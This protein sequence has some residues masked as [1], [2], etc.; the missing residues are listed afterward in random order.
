MNP[1]RNSRLAGVSRTRH[2]KSAAA[3]LLAALA[4]LTPLAAQTSSS[5]SADDIAALRE[6]IRLLDQKI[7]ILERN[8]ELKD[9]AA[10]AAAAKPAAPSPKVSL[11]GKGFVVTSPDKD[12]SL[13]IGAL[14][15]ADARVFLDD[16]APNRDGFLLRRI[17]T[18]LSGTVGKIYNFNIT[19]EYA[20]GNSTTSSVTLVDAWLDARFSPLFGLKAGKYTLPVVLEPGSNRHFNESPFPNTLAPNRDLGIEAFGAFSEGLV[21]YRLGVFNG[22]PNNTQNFG[23]GTPWGE[24]GDFT[25][26]GRLT[27]VPFSKSEGAL[28]KLALSVGGSYGNE[29]A[30]TNGGGLTNIVSN[31]QQAVL[32][33]G[34]LRADGE[35]LRVSPGIE[36]YTGGPFSAAA[37]FIWERQDL[38]NGTTFNKSVTNT[39]WRVSAGYVL[40]GEE[41]TKNGVTPKTPFNWENGTWG[42]F[43][44]VGRLSGL[45]LDSKLFNGAG[46][47]SDTNNIT[48]AFSYGVGL[49]WYLTSNVRALFNV[50]QTEYDG[51]GASTAAVGARS[52]ELYF[53]TRFQLQF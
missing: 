31:G 48:G 10:A 20:G 39:G 25:T 15:Q 2:R 52:D 18:P 41:A 50:E 40:T 51:G 35:H 6:Q 32:S 42:A 29:R 5:A 36:W 21:S 46:S 16:G 26:A 22:A 53:F 9:E 23:G 17:R 49:N 30:S 24:D 12:F 27:V 43:E 13:K 7:R 37:E 44:I 19:P 4:S 34:A 28:S 38:T 1:V 45:D 33:W 47:L 14:V 3:L 8:Q 11:D